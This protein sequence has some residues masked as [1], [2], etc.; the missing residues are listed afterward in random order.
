[1]KLSPIETPDGR[2]IFSMGGQQSYKTDN[3]KG[4]VASLEW[5]GLGKKSAACLVIWPETN[6]FVAGEG[7]G[8]WC[9]GRRAITEFV[10]F[11]SDGKCTGGPSEYCFREAREA[12]PILG[13]DIN[14][15]QA[16]AALVDVVVKFAP[17]LVLMPATPKSVKNQ[18]DTDPMWEVKASIKE[19]GKVI[20]EAMI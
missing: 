19:T 15:K 8:A 13:K 2:P 12:L 4:F 11:N 7:A 5:V 1:M 14:D 17:E 6:V 9:I 16:L 18:L 20:N 3:H 10:G